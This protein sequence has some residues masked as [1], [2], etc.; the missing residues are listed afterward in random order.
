MFI[1]QRTQMRTWLK[2]IKKWAVN[3][4]LTEA[5]EK[6][7]KP[8]PKGNKGLSKLPKDVR[9]EMGFMKNGGTVKKGAGVKSF[10]ARGC[11]AVMNNRRKKT[12]MRG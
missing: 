6:S 11:G 7:L 2:N 12:K 8:I 10:I 4:K 9:N 1:H 5:M 3:T